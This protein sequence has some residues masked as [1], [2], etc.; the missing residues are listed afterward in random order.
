[1]SFRTIWIFMFT[2]SGEPHALGSSG[3]ALTIYELSD[4]D[5][6]VRLEKMGIVF[7]YAELVNGEWKKGDDRHR[8]KNRK[9]TANEADQMAKRLVKKPKK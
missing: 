6:L 5:A 9:K 7:E 3:Q 1:M 2:A 8:R 4:E